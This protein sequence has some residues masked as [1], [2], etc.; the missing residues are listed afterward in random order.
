MASKQ[1]LEQMIYGGVN[2]L[3]LKFDLLSLNLETKQFEPMDS[4]VLQERKLPNGVSNINGAIQINTEQDVRSTLDLEIY[5]GDG[6]NNWGADGDDTS[7]KWWLDKRLVIHIGLLTDNGIEY[8]QLGYFIVTH[9]SSNHSLNEFPTIKIQASS[10]ETLF[11]TRRGKFLFPLTIEA[12]TVITESIKTILT[13]GGEIEKNIL[14]DPQIAKKH[15]LL[16]DGETISEWNYLRN[17][18]TLEL[19]EEDMA[20]G[21]SS[22]KFSIGK[23]QEGVLAAKDFRF[24]LDFSQI[25]AMALWTRA[26]R[27][28]DF[29]ELAIRL[30][31][32]NGETRELPL[33]AMIGHVIDGDNVTN[34][35]NWNNNIIPINEF[36]TFGGVTRLEIV[37]YPKH[38]REPFTLWLDQIYCAEMRNLLPYKLTYNAGDNRWSAIKEL[39]NILDCNC[40]YDKYGRFCLMKRKFPKEI[41]TNEKFE[42]DAYNVLQPII[43][44]SDRQKLYNLYAGANDTF[45]EHELS[46]HVF[47]T[48]G[49]TQTTILSLADIQLKVDGLHIREKGKTLNSRGKVRPIDQ[50]EANSKPTILNGATDVAEVYKGH[51]N[52]EAVLSQYP[53]GFGHLEMPPIQN[54]S[55]ELI[56]DFLYHHNEAN[57]DPLI[58][59]TY[60]AKN[61]ALWELRKRMSYAE[62]VDITLVPFYTLEGNDIIRLE[63]SLL[64]KSENFQIVSIQIPLNGEYMT[65]GAS[66]VKNFLNDI[67]YFDLSGLRSGC[68]YGYDFC[69][70]SFP[71]P[72][73]QG[74]VI[75]NGEE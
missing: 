31:N 15:I 54:F 64:D 1:F 16:D 12:N 38:Q 36:K 65:V 7:F 37:F 61:R 73:R 23:I 58:C 41:N 28:I 67:P 13:G 42:Y 74:S 25:T 5:N 71:Y 11:A 55:T 4:V 24:P 39:A 14:I 10:K 68:W 69:S 34:I 50:F 66:K 75:I 52:L 9:F 27:T 40:Y 47:V 53:N 70:L 21:K 26:S 59:F 44:F 62:Q 48:G 72:M 63:D 19:D 57:P 30:I 2:Q 33:S 49:S 8:E 22:L 20:H 29:E 3:F 35:D 51:Q 17:D 46:N 18:V 43:T 60:E 56:G 32:K 45:E 6:F